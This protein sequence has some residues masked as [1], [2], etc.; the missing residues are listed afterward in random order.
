[1]GM[2]NFLDKTKYF[3]KSLLYGLYAVADLL[4]D[5]R[6]EPKPPDN[7]VGTTS[8]PNI[9]LLFYGIFVIEIISV[10]SAPRPKS[11]YLTTLSN[12]GEK[13]TIVVILSAELYSKTLMTLFICLK[14]RLNK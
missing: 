14:G 13:K 12:A 7:F 11:C 2:N 4:L 9:S 8:E 3:Y 5:P 6:P 10:I 1:M